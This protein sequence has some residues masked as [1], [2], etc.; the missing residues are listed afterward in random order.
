MTVRLA[1]PNLP[2]TVNQIQNLPVAQSFHTADCGE[3]EEREFVIP[4][5]V[6]LGLG[7]LFQS[8]VHAHDADPPH[9]SSTC[10]AIPP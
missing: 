8:H 1:K 6:C 5:V 4:V 2:V 10:R 7:S 9:S 3:A